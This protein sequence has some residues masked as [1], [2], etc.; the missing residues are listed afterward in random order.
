MVDIIIYKVYREIPSVLL[1]TALGLR[2]LAIFTIFGVHVFFKHT[3]WDNLSKYHDDGRLV[4]RPGGKE[5]EPTS[6]G[7]R[8]QA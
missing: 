5:K 2:N 1:S 3:K 6:V 4:L 7:S 8:T